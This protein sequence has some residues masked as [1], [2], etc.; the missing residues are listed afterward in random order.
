VSDLEI[1]GKNAHDARLAA[2]AMRHG[3][4]A[5]LTFNADDFKRFERLTILTPALVLEGKR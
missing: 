5:L 2:A 3:V 4:P 1:K